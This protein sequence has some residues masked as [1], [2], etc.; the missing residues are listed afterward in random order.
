MWALGGAVTYLCC[1]ALTLGALAIGG[2]IVGVMGA[3]QTEWNLPKA[4]TRW[5]WMVG[6]AA[7][8]GGLGGTVLGFVAGRFRTFFD[9]L[10]DSGSSVAWIEVA[11]WGPPLVFLTFVLVAFVHIGLIGRAFEE[12]HRE[13]WSR[14][15]GWLLLISLWWVFVFAIVFHAPVAIK[16]LSAGSLS[17]W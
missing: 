16:Y 8:A 15:A 17:W 10:A 3:S 2:H 11:T 5:C 9:G 4:V 1:W 13:W 12:A 7:V 6:T 14:L